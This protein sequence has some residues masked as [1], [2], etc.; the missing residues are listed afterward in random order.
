EF[1]GSVPLEDVFQN[2]ERATA[3]AYCEFEVEEGSGL[4]KVGSDDGVA[5]WL[6]GRQVHRNLVDR[7]LTID[8]DGVP[9][10]FRAGPNEL[11]VKVSQSGGGWSFSVRVTDAQGAPID[12]SR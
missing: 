11:L 8:Q 1:E 3:Y 6:N 7:G 12:M 10:T 9:V 4:L 5:V 2:V